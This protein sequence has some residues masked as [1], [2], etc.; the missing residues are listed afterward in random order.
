[1]KPS[2]AD[3]Q[4]SDPDGPGQ[5]DWSRLDAYGDHAERWRRYAQRTRSPPSLKRLPTT[6]RLSVAMV[7]SWVLMIALGALAALIIVAAV[8][9]THH[10]AGPGEVHA[11]R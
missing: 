8:P 10:W 2:E 9:R 5:R 1:M 11:T 4:P 3:R 7:L 6:P